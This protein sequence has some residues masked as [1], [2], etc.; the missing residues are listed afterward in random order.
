MKP[1]PLPDKRPATRHAIRSHRKTE[2]YS[3][4][5]KIIGT[6]A[7]IAKDAKPDQSIPGALRALIGEI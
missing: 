3:D 5:N 6:L 4:Q 1:P 2:R 7:K